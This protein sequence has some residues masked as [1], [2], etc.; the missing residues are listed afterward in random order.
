MLLQKLLEKYKVFDILRTVLRD[1]FVQWKPT[2]CTI[3]ELYFDKYLYMF[4][5]DLLSNIRSLDTLFTTIG[6]CN[7]E[8]L[9]WVKLLVYIVVK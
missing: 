9:K 7:T 8:I 5:T 1:I 3:S 6:I 4:R 2:R